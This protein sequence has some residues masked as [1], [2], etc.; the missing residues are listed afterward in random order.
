[1]PESR[2]SG[3]VS[4]APVGNGLP[5]R[6]VGDPCEF[7]GSEKRRP[8]SNRCAGCG[9]F[10]SDPRYAKSPM[11]GNYYRVREW[12][13]LGDGKIKAREKEKVDREDVPGEWLEVLD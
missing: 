11:T 13:D 2:N 4:P 3:N 12:D 6:D 5:L 10:A 9:R 1:M 8:D 7:C